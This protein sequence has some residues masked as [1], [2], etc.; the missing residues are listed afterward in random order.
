MQVKGLLDR[1]M[2]D[3]NHFKSNTERSSLYSVVSYPFKLMS[4]NAD[5]R[6]VGLKLQVLGLVD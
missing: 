2:L 4:M 3:Q 5:L 6:H 1:N